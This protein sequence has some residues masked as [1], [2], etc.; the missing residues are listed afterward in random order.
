MIRRR[1]MKKDAVTESVT[2]ESGLNKEAINKKREE[3]KK[4][5]DCV[6]NKINDVE[7]TRQSLTIELIRIDGQLKLLDEL[8]KK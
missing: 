4:L 6:I 8:S 1:N 2:S 3:L 5:Y 7:K